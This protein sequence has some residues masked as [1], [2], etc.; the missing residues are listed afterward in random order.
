M[1]TFRDFGRKGDLGNQ[2]FQLCSLVGIARSLGYEWG[3]PAS[4]AGGKHETALFRYFELAKFRQINAYENETSFLPR[5]V[6]RP[7]RLM[8]S[9]GIRYDHGLKTRLPDNRDISAYLQ[10]WRYFHELRSEILEQF[11]VKQNYKLGVT[12]TSDY[13]AI[14]VRRGDYLK[15]KATHRVL[16]MNYYREAIELL[17]RLPLRIV[18]Q[19]QDAEWVMNSPLVQELGGELVSGTEIEDWQV[20]AQ[21]K[22]AIIANSTFSYSA[23]YC[24]TKI[25]TVIAPRVWFGWSYSKSQSKDICPPEWIQI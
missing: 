1:I 18:T 13:I 4:H 3:V 14:H 25:Q 10:S 2:F 8:D 16:T 21:G 23:A 9:T 20:L 15:H 24:S 17:P 19:R 7:N 22:Y 5:Y 12:Q 11:L 6:S